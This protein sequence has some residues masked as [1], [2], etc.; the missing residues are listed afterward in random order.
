[1]QPKRPKNPQGRP[2]PRKPLAPRRANASSPLRSPKQGAG[3]AAPAGGYRGSPP[4]LEN[5]GGWAGGTTAQAKLDPP[6]KEGV[7][8]DKTIRP[9]R[10]AD[11]GVWGSCHPPLQNTNYCAMIP[12]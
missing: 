12:P 9:H 11:A 4:V 6:L 1:M 5:V 3:G 2:P 8:Q 10:R 7:R